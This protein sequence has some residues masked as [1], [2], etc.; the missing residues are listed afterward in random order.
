MIFNITVTMISI[1]IVTIISVI[2][3]AISTMIGALT[4]GARRSVVVLALLG[5]VYTNIYMYICI[6]I[7]VCIYIYI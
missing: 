7:Y 2:S 5:R 6:Y 4:G 1:F 3:I